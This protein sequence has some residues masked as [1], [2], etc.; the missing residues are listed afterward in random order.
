LLLL[1]MIIPSFP[2]ELVLTSIHCRLEASGWPG[3]SQALGIR[4][5]LLRQPGLW[6]KQQQVVVLW[7]ETAIL[8]VERPRFKV[9]VPSSQCPVYELAIL[10][11]KFTEWVCSCIL[12]E[13]QNKSAHLLWW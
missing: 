7:W 10:I 4:L 13:D 8:T 9:W 11:L 1:M 12:S 2:P 6:T 5:G 3:T